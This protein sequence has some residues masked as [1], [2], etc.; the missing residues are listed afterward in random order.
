MSPREQDLLDD[1]EQGSLLRDSP[2]AAARNS[3]SSHRSS[4]DSTT[5]VSTTSLVLEN[6]NTNASLY[7][8]KHR[9][10][11]P[12]DYRDD[13][14]D[15]ELPR[16]KWSNHKRTVS[17]GS[18]TMSKVLKRSVW[19]ISVIAVAG[20]IVA[21]FSLL[22]SKAY[23]HSSTKAYDHEAPGKSSGRKVSLESIQ[24]GQWYPRHVNLNWIAGANEEDGLLLEIS[25][26]G[27]D[28]MVVE[29]VRSRKGGNV[30]GEKIH[31]S[32]TLMKSGR[33]TPRGGDSVVVVEDYWP[34]PDLSKVLVLAKREKVYRHSFTGVYYVFDVESQTAESL[35]EAAPG[36]R[37]Q[38]ASWSP[39]GDAIVFTRDND[40][41]V[42]IL[43]DSNGRA[44]TAVRQITKDGGPEFFYGIPDWVFDFVIC[45]K[46]RR[47][48]ISRVQCLSP[49]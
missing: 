11:S 30:E 2:V 23:Q 32:K 12:L 21:L 38:L 22:N 10:S 43:K 3:L 35:D 25:Q 33:F 49:V 9:P 27:K 44:T 15:P 41:F 7:A 47:E 14:S 1:S 34:S 24:T 46:C 28:F 4:F 37:V 40:L 8:E 20:W 19:I 16:A 6:L 26:P 17:S 39:E 45:N 29:D 13:E 5:S 48:A 18:Q 36:G 31:E 42:R